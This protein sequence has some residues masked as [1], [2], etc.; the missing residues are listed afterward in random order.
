MRGV[1]VSN[2]WLGWYLAVTGATFA[3]GCSSCDKKERPVVSHPAA[4]QAPE[5]APAEPMARWAWRENRALD[6]AMPAG[7]TLARPALWYPTATENLFFL[8]Q[9]H[10]ASHLAAARAR[11]D[12]SGIVAS[13][14]LLPLGDPTAVVRDIPWSFIGEPPVMGASQGRWLALV[15]RV[16]PMDS[17]A[18]LWLWREPRSVVL[19]AEGDGLRAL[20]ARCDGPAC[21]LTTTQPAQVATSKL[22]VW[23]G[24]YESDVNKLQTVDVPAPDRE[25]RLVGVASFRADEN[26]GV[27][28]FETADSVV[29]HRV[30]PQGVQPAG[31]VPHEGDVI[32]VA[33]TSSSPVAAMVRGTFNEQGCSTTA[34]SVV[35]ARPG[36]ERVEIALSSPPL[37][38]YVRPVGNAALVSWLAPVN[39]KVNA[40]KIVYAALVSDDAAQPVAGVPVGDAEGFT[41]TTVG[42]DVHMWLRAARGVAWLQLRCAAEPA[43]AR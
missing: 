20:D 40:R 31:S 4:A 41:V 28:A 35:V 22:R 34:M 30:S 25:A 24:P 9:P 32:D 38:G 17:W 8:S 27:L 2:R 13:R 37:S 16:D 19:L 29:F 15:A 6:L 39:C 18:S 23:F 11:N 21:M 43:P 12:D 33:A 3:L 14:G 10:D 1:L 5:L 7:C 36:R 42:N 26:A